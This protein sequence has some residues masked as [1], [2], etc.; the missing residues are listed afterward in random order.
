MDIRG[1]ALCVVGGALVAACE[2]TPSGPPAAASVPGAPALWTWRPM[3][4]QGYS[5]ATDRDGARS[6]AAAA[7]VSITAAA[8]GSPYASLS[9]SVRADAHR[10]RRVRW[11]GWLRTAAIAGEGAALW[12]QIDGAGVIQGF[13]NMPSRTV[14]STSGWQ[15]FSVVLDV[16]ANAIGISFG[17]FVS[18][19]GDLLADDFALEDVSNTV[20]AT[21][22]Q[23]GDVPSYADPDVTAEYYARSPVAPANLDF[24]GLGDLVADAAAWLTNVA[25]PLATTQPGPDVSDLAPLGAMVGAAHLV[26]MG[27]GTHGTR[28]FFQLKH[29]VFQFLV[30]EMGFT[31]FAI[32]ASWPEADDVNRYVLTGQGDPAHLLSRLYFWTWNAGEVLALIEWMREWNVTAPASR[33]V[34]FLGFDI[35]FPG[36]AMDSVASFIGRVDSARASF[37][38]SKYECIAPY[39]N[40][41]AVFSRSPTDYAALP[42]TERDACNRSLQDVIDLIGANSVSYSGA[43]SDSAYSRALHSARAVQ[44]FEELASASGSSSAS[45]VAV[46]D[47]CM[48]ENVQWLM[49]QAGPGARMMLWAHNG[50][51]ASRS[52]WMGGALRTV[53]GADYVNLGFLFGTGSFNARGLEGGTPTDLRTFNASLVPEGSLESVFMATGRPLLLFDTRLVA[54]G[55]SAAAPLAGPIGMRSIGAAFDSDNEAGSFAPSLFP[56]DY[57]LLMHVRAATPS[58]LLPFVR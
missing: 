52:G 8:G 26:G 58:T 54:G 4:A 53:Y 1:M 3:G 34:Q 30:R 41:G 44:Q 12:M 48:A 55:G 7:H 37:V 18:G 51:V 50:H 32:E 28:E 21:N 43:S 2:N 57:Q 38:G 9:Q 33:R 42:Q 39:R 20:P 10:G 40:N 22:I 23:S 14:R 6:G 29:R 19:T 11:S 36:A 49:R 13:D 24:E 35:Q 47:R 27:E 31:H 5:V 15:R 16:P 45:A 56:S 46:R 25:A 17:F